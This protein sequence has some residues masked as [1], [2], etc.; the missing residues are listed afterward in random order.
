MDWTPGR[1][2]L[3]DDPNAN[4]DSIVCSGGYVYGEKVGWDRITASTA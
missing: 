1:A 4:V 2:L 3:R